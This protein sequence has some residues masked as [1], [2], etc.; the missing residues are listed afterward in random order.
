[1]GQNALDQPDFELNIPLEQ[2][3]EMAWVFA[4]WYNFVEIGN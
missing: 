1:M 2:N 4:C 3:N